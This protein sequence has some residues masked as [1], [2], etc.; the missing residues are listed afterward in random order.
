MFLNFMKADRT[1]RN[2]EPKAVTVF[3]QNNKMMHTFVIIQLQ[4]A[5]YNTLKYCIS[6]Q[7]G[8]L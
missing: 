1:H 6:S 8:T 5:V 7:G 4:D 2:Q 3:I